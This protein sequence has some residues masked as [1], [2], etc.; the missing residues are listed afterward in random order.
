SDQRRGGARPAFEGQQHVRKLSD[1]RITANSPA[2]QTSTEELPVFPDASEF[3]F[4]D[5]TDKPNNPMTV[6]GGRPTTVHIS[7]LSA[8]SVVLGCNIYPSYTDFT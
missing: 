7:G 4:R 1:M 2:S 6:S 3:D 8:L 5:P